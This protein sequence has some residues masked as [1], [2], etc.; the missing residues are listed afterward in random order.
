[1]P[2]HKIL[3]EANL[4]SEINIIGANPTK[5]SKTLKQFVSKNRQIA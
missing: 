3:V 5:W 1:M 2:A 4:G